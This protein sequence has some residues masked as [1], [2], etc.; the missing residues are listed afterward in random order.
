MLTQPSA[1]T[2]DLSS[3]LTSPPMPE[4]HAAP[5]LQQAPL[6]TPGATVTSLLPIDVPAAPPA[7]PA[8]GAQVAELSQPAAGNVLWAQEGE[9]ARATP[10][11]SLGSEQHGSG[12][13]RP[14]AW[15][16][17]PKGCHMGAQ[18]TFCHLCPEGEIKSRKKAKV[19]AIRH[20][21]QQGNAAIGRT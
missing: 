14:C 10:A 11:R 18:C 5:W 8:A 17:K 15:Y 6:W 16:Y 1:Y 4:Q 12:E 19:A 7:A 3:I 21:L 13:C 9:A 2:L 20:S